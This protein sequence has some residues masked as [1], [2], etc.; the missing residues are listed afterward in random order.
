MTGIP[1]FKHID[2]TPAVKIET[3]RFEPPSTF[4][5]V[6]D[7]IKNSIT[8]IGT[9]IGNFVPRNL[10]IQ[11]PGSSIFNGST[12]KPDA[13]SLSDQFATLKATVSNTVGGIPSFTNL[14]KSTP[15]LDSTHTTWN[16]QIALGGSQKSFYDPILEG[17]TKIQNQGTLAWNQ[18]TR[19]LDETRQSAM[20]LLDG[21]P[22]SE[23]GKWA[24]NW[25][26]NLSGTARN[27]F[28]AETAAPGST[29]AEI[30]ASGL[31]SILKQPATLLNGIA[32]VGAATLSPI[33]ALATWPIGIAKDTARTLYDLLPDFNFV[34]TAKAATP[35][36]KTQPDADPVLSTEKV[37]PKN[38]QER[39]KQLFPNVSD[40]PFS[41][42]SPLSLNTHNI[43]KTA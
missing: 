30:E 20:A 42:S 18:G 11:P 36:A 32:E 14:F 27:N 9:H 28:I 31:P 39:W 6:T 5:K 38:Q 17:L 34:S 23:I 37:I 1:G 35:E 21:P 12:Y 4:S 7:S 33:T 24:S 3:P 8:D 40:E 25:L 29:R 15:K 2:Y 22:Q 43:D 10:D 19:A 16:N 41:F 13:P 26:E